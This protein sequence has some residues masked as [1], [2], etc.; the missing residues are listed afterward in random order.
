VSPPERVLRVGDL[1]VLIA[2]RLMEGDAFKDLW[3]EGEVSEMT[4]SA[5]GHTY[6]TLRDNVAQ[7][8][9]TLFATAAARIALSPRVGLR[10]LA[11]G[12]LDV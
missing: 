6:F 11:H 1:S 12:A 8:R 7:I 2:R 9:C 10:I 4:A 5:A 3:V